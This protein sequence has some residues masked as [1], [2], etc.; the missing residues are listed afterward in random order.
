MKKHLVLGLMTSAILFSSCSTDNNE[1][2]KK[3][4]L[5]KVTTIYYDNPSAPETVV[6]TL[7]Y[8]SQGQLVKM[9]SKGRS[10]IFEYNN[11]KPVKTTYYNDKQ[12]MEYYLNFY[13]QGDRLTANK[14][15][16]TNS[17]FS[18]TYSYAYNASGQLTSST[19]C[20]SEDCSDPRVSSFTYSGGNVS[21]ET[22]VTSGTY[23][24]AFKSEFSYDN[25]QSPYSNVNKYLR[26]MMGRA[27]TLSTNNYLIDKSSSRVQNGSWS[28]GETTTYTIQYN[29]TGLPV[30]AIG[31]G[32]D[33]NLS[34]QYIYEYIS[35]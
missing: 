25:K 9:Q 11:G 6:E 16:Y 21:V 14:A 35:Q 20:Q 4:L 5:S 32:S 3:L 26:I 24:L 17:G 23:G 28:P 8:D 30:Q 33:G 15:V 12:V 1:P 29:N 10:S 7:E 19:L 13:Y 27:A 22:D 31:K 18:R 2:E 34:V